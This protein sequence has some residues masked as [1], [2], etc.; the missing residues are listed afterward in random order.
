LIHYLGIDLGGTN[1]K[2]AVIGVEPESTPSVVATSTAATQAERGP[3]A[4][5]QRMIDMGIEMAAMEGPF[6]GVG[7]GVPGLFDFGTGEIVFFTNLSGAWE[8]FP[9]RATM[10]E[11]LGI[12]ATMINDARA[13]TLAEATVGAG[14]GCS[15]VACLTLGTGVGGG[16]FINDELHFG[17]F[18][19]AG[20]L[21]HQTVAPDGPTC[22]CGNPGCMEAMTRAPVIAA[23]A[24]RATMEDVL[25]GAAAGDP[26]CTAAIEQ[27]ATYLGIGLANV[28]TIIGPERIV[29]GGGVAAAGD[30]LL[31]PIR[32]AVRARI[33]LVPPEQIE[34]VAAELGSRAGAI[35]AALAAVVSPTRDQRFLAG[36]IPSAMMRREQGPVTGR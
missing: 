34:V 17:A 10:A 11:G 7:I 22:G 19:V 24:G 25:A 15:T 4:V 26:A 23:A 30:A 29:I 9:L 12:P 36:E 1:I 2:G 20:E 35:G 16:L 33:T 8:G 13:F 6:A 27:A 3:A 31:D 14:R 32:D 5:A 21:G 18:G 28:V